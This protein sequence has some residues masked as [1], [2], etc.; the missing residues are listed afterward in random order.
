MNICISH[1]TTPNLQQIFV[2]IEQHCKSKNVRLLIDAEQ[3][4]LEGGNSHLVLALQ[5]KYNKWKPWVYGTYQCYR[6]V[7]CH[8]LELH[9]FAKY[10]ICTRGFLAS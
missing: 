8:T 10:A 5:S 1:T 3:Y 4:Y 9:A 7:R 6:K 2:W